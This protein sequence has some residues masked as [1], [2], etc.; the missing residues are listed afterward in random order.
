MV[1]SRK[2]V[3]VPV[4]CPP[5][6]N[7][8]PNGLLPKTESPTTATETDRHGPWRKHYLVAGGHLLQY[9]VVYVIQLRD[10]NATQW[11]QLIVLQRYPCES[12]I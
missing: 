8:A 10:L 2:P 5:T 11:R 3:V 9:S 12:I 6:Q 7:H 4:E 1:C